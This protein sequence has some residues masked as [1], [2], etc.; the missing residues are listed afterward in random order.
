MA[1]ILDKALV[2]ETGLVNAEGRDV[3]VMLIPGE[4]GGTLAFRE[5]GKGG[6]GIETTL[7]KIL[8]AISDGTQPE[9]VRKPEEGAEDVVDLIDVAVLESRIMI[10]H[11]DVMSTDVKSKLFEIFREIR[12]ERREDLA[13]PPLIHGSKRNSAKRAAL[14]VRV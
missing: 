1:T 8:E 5:K 9:A 4:D 7:K 12:E 14:E 2:R 3:F 11:P 10:Q 13:L 6:K